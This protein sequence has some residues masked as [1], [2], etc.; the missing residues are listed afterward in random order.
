M[1]FFLLSHRL[2]I[3]PISSTFRVPNHSLD[4]SNASIS[5][6]PNAPARGSSDGR[7]PLDKVGQRDLVLGRD[8]LAG[9]A[10]VDVVEGLAARGH[11]GLDRHG[12]AD[13]VTGLGGSRG[14]ADDGDA[15]VLFGKAELVNDLQSTTTGNDI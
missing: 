9:L 2:P 3:L 14:V 4:Y 15:D 8:G 5:L 12:C 10:R 1:L 11:A 6:R 13:G 7:V